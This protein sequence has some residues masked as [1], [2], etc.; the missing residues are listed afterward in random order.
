MSSC[1]GTKLEDFLAWQYNLTVAG[2]DDPNFSLAFAEMMGTVAPRPTLTP[3][4]FAP[5]VA[6]FEQYR[7]QCEDKLL[8]FDDETSWRM[9]AGYNFEFM[10]S[11]EHDAWVENYLRTLALTLSASASVGPIGV[12][13]EIGCCGCPKGHS[14]EQ[15]EVLEHEESHRVT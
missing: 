15:F 4:Q 12:P 13:G 9:Y 7:G 6:H 1:P 8:D 2:S 10:E 3:A 5:I 14:T 11:P